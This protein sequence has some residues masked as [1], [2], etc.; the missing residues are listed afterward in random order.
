LYG[1]RVELETHVFLVSTYSSVQLSQRLI[2]PLITKVSK[3]M[4]ADQ[5]I[6]MLDLQKQTN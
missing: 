4:I 1:F 3:T 2:S 5:A 6:S